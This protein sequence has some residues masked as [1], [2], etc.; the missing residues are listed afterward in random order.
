M[1]VDCGVYCKYTAKFCGMAVEW[2]GRKAASKV[3][4]HI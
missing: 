1:A 3:T 4:N 2:G